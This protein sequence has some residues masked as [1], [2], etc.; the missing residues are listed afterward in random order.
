MISLGLLIL[1]LVV[2]LTVAGHGAQKLFG[3]W[4]G[5]GVSGTRG[6]VTRMRFRPVELW[7][8][9]LVAG[10]FGGGLLLA[11][12]LLSPLGSFGILGAMAVAIWIVHV[13][14]G[15]WARDG[16]AEFPLTVASAALALSLTGPG[17]YSLDHLLHLALPEPATWLVLAAGTIL[18]VLA[19]M[20][21]RPASAVGQ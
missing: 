5:A 18:A 17:D 19:G 9:A 10:E 12:G 2:G 15:F 14:K 21:S 3:W 1:R 11:L 8:W 20:A 13:P 6:M 16:G 4:G 7:T